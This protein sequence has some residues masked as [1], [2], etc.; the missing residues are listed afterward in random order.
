VEEA[1]RAIRKLAH[2]GMRKIN[3]AGGEPFLQQE[4]LGTLVKFC[5]VDLKRYNLA[6]SIVSNGS[7]IRRSWM[8]KYA[9]Y[10]DVLAVSCDS[11]IEDVNKLIGRSDGKTDHIAKM[12]QVSAWCREFNIKF[13]INSVV[14]SYNWEEDMSP[15]IAELAPFRW[16]CFQVLTLDN[17][18][19]SGRERDATLFKVSNEQFAHFCKRHAHHACMVPESNESMQNSYLILDEK[20][21]F[22]NCQNDTKE[23]S[24]SILDV[25]VQVALSQAGWD[26]EEFLKRGG[27]YNFYKEPPKSIGCSA[28]IPKELE[29]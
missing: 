5:K 29:F 2:A 10:V 12:R 6:V 17:Q 27:V 22:L 14:C 3:F 7:L 13:K 11:F 21:R 24:S 4:F 16:K 8:I 26:P 28:G 18:N 23:P 15:M 1:T 9:K 19:G 20:L 25:D